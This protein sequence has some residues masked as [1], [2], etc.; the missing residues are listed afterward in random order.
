MSRPT[1]IEYQGRT[2]Q[3]RAMAFQPVKEDWNIYRLEDGTLVKV[4]VVPS[5][6]VVTE[7]KNA[8]G[9]PLI[10]VKASTIR[11]LR[12]QEAGEARY[13]PFS[14]QVTRPNGSSPTRARVPIAAVS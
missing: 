10:L 9:D 5:D 7:G 14:T 4:R 12:A 8:M 1:E 6:F 11:R 3:G 2:L 13:K